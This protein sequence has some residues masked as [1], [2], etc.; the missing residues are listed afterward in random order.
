MR[1]IQDFYPESYAVCYG[2]GRLNEYGHQV[3]SFWEGD[4]AI[5]HFRPEPFHTAVAG[6]TYGGL[7]A[8]LIDCHATGTASIAMAQ[9]ENREPGTE[10]VYRFVTG[11][12][13]VRYEAP[14]PIDQT[15]ELRAMVS[16]IKGR[17]VVVHVDLYA[18]DVR[19]VQGDVIVFQVPENMAAV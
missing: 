1:A 11:S 19:T 10:P 14:T 4:T 18:G 3:K 5:C 13:N 16:E 2:C 8:S 17:K 9:R 6:F 12:L 7:L 15:L